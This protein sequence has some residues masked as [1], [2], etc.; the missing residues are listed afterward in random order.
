VALTAAT[1]K[2]VHPLKEQQ[3]RV[4]LSEAALSFLSSQPPEAQQRLQQEVNRFVLW[5]GREQD[6]SKITVNEVAKYAESVMASDADAQNRLLPVRDFL[7]YAKKSGLVKSSLSPHLGTRKTSSK[8][9]RKPKQERNPEQVIVTQE[10][11]DGMLTELEGLKE[12]RPHIAEELRRAAADKDFRENAPLEAA[13]ERQ[14][15][16]EGRIRE[17][18]AMLNA[19]MVLQE[20]DEETR[21]AKM[22]STVVLRDLASGQEVT[23]TLVGPREI[24]PLEGKISV[25]SPVGK[26][27]MDRQEG[28]GVEVSAPSGTLSYRIERITP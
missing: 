3:Q 22:N 12:E 6:I 7:N 24:A 27:L 26:A 9:T 14:G 10:A 1:K 19:A 25:L 18:E 23:Y 5:Y 8:A 17:L 2:R 11:F 16:I 13:K 15:H 4:T 28:D 20:K 21:R